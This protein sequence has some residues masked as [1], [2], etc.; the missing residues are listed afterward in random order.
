[1]MAF[2]A[3]LVPLVV[4]TI[5]SVVYFRYGRSVQYEEFLVQARNAHAIAIGLTD[6]IAQREAWQ[7]E[8]SYLNSAE[9]NS[10][11]TE[12]QTMRQEAQAKLDQLE[13]ISRLQFQPVVSGLNAQISR[14]A[15]NE[16][17]LYL[18]DAV[19]GDVLHVAIN[20]TGFPD[21]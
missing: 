1:M 10:Q 13:G 4:V 11:T 17:N 16:N 12:T 8:L 21:R 18:L 6:P 5:A 20:T 3:I 19:R 14:M 7:Q 2:I 15:A 9:S